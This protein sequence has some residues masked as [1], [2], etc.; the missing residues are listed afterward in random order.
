VGGDFYTD[1]LPRGAD[2]AWLGAIVHQNSRPQNRDLLAKA[3]RALVPGG[4]VVI[5][6]VLMDPS[7]TRPL[8]GALFA[9]AMLV[10]YGGRTYTFGELRDDLQAAGF[11]DV[12]LIDPGRWMDGLI[13]AT[14]P[15][16]VQPRSDAT[17][18][19]P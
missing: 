6:D 11:V 3:F 5:R 4:H 18:G 15:D 17:T 2:V 19:E 9:I 13:R 14:K 8:A 7:H 1:D 16:G 10:G 12:T